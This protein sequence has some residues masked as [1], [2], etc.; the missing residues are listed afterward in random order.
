MQSNIRKKLGVLLLIAS[1]FCCGWWLSEKYIKEIRY[2]LVDPVSAEY[3]GWNKEDNTFDFKLH[4]NDK[5]T[6]CTYTSLGVNDNTAHIADI[7]LT[8]NRERLM[9]SNYTL[10]EK[11][12]IYILKNPPMPLSYILPELLNVANPDIKTWLPSL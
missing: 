4:Y 9:I 1:S 12:D 7:I 5:I 6:H 8:I 10:N 2:F 11:M 3:I